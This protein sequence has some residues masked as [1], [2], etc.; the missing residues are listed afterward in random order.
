MSNFKKIARRK[1][2]VNEPRERAKPHIWKPY[3]AKKKGV[4]NVQGM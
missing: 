2:I 4:N 1:Y 3:K